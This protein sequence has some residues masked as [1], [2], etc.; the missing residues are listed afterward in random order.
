MP[1]NHEKAHEKGHE[2]DTKMKLLYKN[3]N[4]C[5]RQFFEELNRENLDIDHALDSMGYTIKEHENKRKY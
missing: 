3:M 2:K 1:I 4:K 5:I